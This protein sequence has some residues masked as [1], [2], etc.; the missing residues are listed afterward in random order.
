MPEK[1]IPKSILK[2][3]SRETVV[4]EDSSSVNC[5]RRKCQIN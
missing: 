2:E 5:G 1:D 3:G 4:E